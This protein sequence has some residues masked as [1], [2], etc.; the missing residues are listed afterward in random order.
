MSRVQ[1]AHVLALSGGV[2]GAR[3]AAGLQRLL[4]TGGLT[5]LVNTADDFEHLGLR[6]SP[7]LDTVLY[8]LADRHNA[9]EGWGRAGESWRAMEALAELGGPSW[10]RLGDTDLATHLYRTHRLGQGATL[11]DVSLELSSRLGVTANLLPMSDDPVRSIVETDEGPLTFQDWFVRRQCRVPVTGLRFEGIDAAR[12]TAGFAAA[13]AGASCVLLGPS[14][15]WVSID[16]ILRVAGIGDV[17]KRSRVPVVGVSPIIGGRAVKGPAANMLGWLGEEVSSFGI[18]NWYAQQHP[19]LLDL[20]VMDQAD[21]ALSPR[22]ADLGLQVFVTD[23]LMRDAASA[24][25]LARDVLD[26]LP[27]ATG[28]ESVS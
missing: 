7:D 26:H 24:T 10:F 22:V 18:A 3:L 1:P 19:G 13:L 16:P 28:R 14:N 4:P 27:A 8:T 25:R 23:T 11:T 12:P 6:I 15:P 2:G 20:W 21:A 9:V 5:V 17:L